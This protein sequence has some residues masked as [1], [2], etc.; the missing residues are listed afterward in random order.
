MAAATFDSFRYGLAVLL[1]RCPD[2]RRYAHIAHWWT[3][4]IENYGD[5]VRFRDKLRDEDGDRLLLDEYE[6]LCTE[7][8]AELHSHFGA[9]GML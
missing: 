6:Q 5:A 4:E 2:L 7:L 1:V 8:E 3:E 9:S